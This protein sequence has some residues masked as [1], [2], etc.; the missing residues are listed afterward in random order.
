[1]EEIQESNGLL[2]KAVTLEPNNAEALLLQGKIDHKLGEWQ[3]AIDA[4]EKAI[5][6]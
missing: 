2:I 6:V 4:L 1:M 3:S 5:K